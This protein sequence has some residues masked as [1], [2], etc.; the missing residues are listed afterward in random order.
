MLFFIQQW[1]RYVMLEVVLVSTLD[2]GGH[3]FV[4]LTFRHAC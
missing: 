4:I 2:K 3:V 1:T